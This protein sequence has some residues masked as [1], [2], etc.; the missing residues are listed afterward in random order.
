V[1]SRCQHQVAALRFTSERVSEWPSPGG[2]R[3]ATSS[4][5]RHRLH[6]VPIEASVRSHIDGPSLTDFTPSAVREATSATQHHVCGLLGSIGNGLCCS[7]TS[8]TDAQLRRS[9]QRCRLGN[10]CKIQKEWVGMRQQ[11]SSC[12]TRAYSWQHSHTR[13]HFSSFHFP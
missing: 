8:E 7:G 12:Q 3:A 2:R 10:S 6:C 9:W 1:R 11:W 13:A 5:S 4:T